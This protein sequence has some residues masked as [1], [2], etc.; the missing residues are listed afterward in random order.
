[1]PLA[2]INVEMTTEPLCGKYRRLA[3][4][5]KQTVKVVTAVARE[6]VGFIWDIARNTPIVAMEPQR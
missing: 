3:N 4:A 5:G 6:L 1:M 2:C